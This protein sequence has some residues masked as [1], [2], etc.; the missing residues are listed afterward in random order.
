MTSGLLHEEHADFQPLLLAVA[1]DA[2][3]GVELVR[4]ADLCGDVLALLL[5]FR[6]AAEHQA[7]D[8]AAAGGVG[9]FEV[10]ENGEVFVNRRVLEFPADAGADDP[11][12]PDAAEFLALELDAAAGG[13]R[14]AADQVEH[15]GLAGAVRA[16]DDVHVVLER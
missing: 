5:D 1:E 9:E 4:Q 13:E 12:F 15:G 16:D 2:G 14:L 6:R 8:H 10:F 3:L 7:A 11:V